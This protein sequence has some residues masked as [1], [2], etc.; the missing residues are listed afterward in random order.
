MDLTRTIEVSVHVR[1][2]GSDRLTNGRA[3]ARRG[4]DGNEDT[5]ED[6]PGVAL[7]RRRHHDARTP[8]R[9]HGEGTEEG[10]V[11]MMPVQ[12]SPNGEKTMAVTVLSEVARTPII[13]L[14]ELENI[15]P[16]EA[17]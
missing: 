15:D 3:S 16:R 14:G 4:E 10:R 12:C 8:F 1:L 11:G 7:G 6:S 5:G 17:R 13:L 2:R 9:A